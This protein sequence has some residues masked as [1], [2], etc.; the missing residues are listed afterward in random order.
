MSSE[1]NGSLGIVKLALS[2]LSN[3][4]HKCA[5]RG[6]ANDDVH[7]VAQKAG[8]NLERAPTKSPAIHVVDSILQADIDESTSKGSGSFIGTLASR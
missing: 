7:E 2:E 4:R 5:F 6:A 8:T 3:R 1:L